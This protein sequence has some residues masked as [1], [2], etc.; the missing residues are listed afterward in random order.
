M[1]AYE[2]YQNRDELGADLVGRGEHATTGDPWR[3]GYDRDHPAGT[4]EQ[5]RR[6]R[7]QRDEPIGEE[8]KVLDGRPDAN[9]PALLTQDVPG[10]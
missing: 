3:T 10:G 4:L 2:A 9:I 6:E 8:E 5:L 7:D 1:I